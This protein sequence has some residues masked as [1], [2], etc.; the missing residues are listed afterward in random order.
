MCEALHH[1]PFK[2]LVRDR[3][4]ELRSLKNAIPRF[5]A[6]VVPW[7]KGPVWEGFTRQLSMARLRNT[8]RI[9]SCESGQSARGSGMLTMPAL[10]SKKNSLQSL[11]T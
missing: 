6:F 1:G 3:H 9:G 7:L 2:I 10:G 8:G 11:V 5:I 4:R